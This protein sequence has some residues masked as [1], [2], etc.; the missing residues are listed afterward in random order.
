[1]SSATASSPGP[2]LALRPYQQEAVER[3]LQASARGVSR[4]LISLPTGSG[5]THIFSH[6][7]QQRGGRAL[8]LAHRDELVLQ[9]VEKLSMIMPTVK[10]GIVQA[11]RNEVD[12]D[13]IVASVQTVCRAR[14]L[15]QLPTSIC[16]LVVDEAHHA[17]T[18]TYRRVLASLKA[19]L[20]LGVTATPDRGDGLGL[21]AV[22][23]DIV[24]EKT[25]LWMIEAGYLCDLRATRI[26]IASLDLDRVHVRAGDLDAG[27]L[28]DALE[29][30]HAPEVVARAYV[31]HA[32]G[33]PT[34]V[35]TASVDLAHATA[36]ALEDRGVRAAAI[37]GGMP[38]DDRRQLLHQ[39]QVGA[40]DVIANCAVLNEGFDQP[41]LS[42]IG[43]ARP[44]KS[45]LLY[46][47]MV[48]RGTR[49]YPGKA[50]CLVLDFVGATSRHE[51]VTLA[52]LVGVSAEA[53]EEAG[54]V[55]GAA[56]ADRRAAAQQTAHG[57]LVA[58][59]V[60]LFDRHRLHWA[61]PSSD[62]FVLSL[63]AGGNVRLTT[64]DFSHWDVTRVDLD[65]QKHVLATNLSLEYA[66]GVA[67]DL[68]RQ[69][70]ARILNDPTA[71]WR[72]DP[73]TEKQ[74]L[75]LRKFRIPISPDLTKGTAKDLLDIAI[76]R[77]S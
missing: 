60:N 16:T 34:L 52:S 41:R 32:A 35:F 65:R 50:D 49:T 24:F 19:E 72:K 46:Q 8:V 5:K 13:I 11:E 51:L 76:A 70:D 25:L 38:R 73:P 3:V 43:I 6:V 23:D 54:T 62:L 18:D 56:A 10:V 1:V 64:F 31:E 2:T 44:T 58:E 42:C 74:L 37:D 9:A 33:R 39:L 75:A 28:A 26:R 40:L 71:R 29:T 67:E 66:Q 30:A 68:V 22:F 61:S 14:R 59:S 77:I 17:V 21:D 47:Q 12:A 55:A 36:E 45:R 69:F 4:Q 53:L 20:V 63:G 15:A 7:I 57:R 48:G 27:E